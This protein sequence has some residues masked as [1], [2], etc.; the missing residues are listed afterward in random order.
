[1][2]FQVGHHKR[3]KEG[4]KKKKHTYVTPFLDSI[5]LAATDSINIAI[6]I[7]EGKACG[8]I[9]KSGRIPVAP[10]NGISTSGHSW[11]QTP[12]CPCLLLN[13]SP[14]TG[15]RGC[16]KRIFTLIGKKK[17][18]QED[19]IRLFLFPRKQYQLKTKKANDKF[20]TNRGAKEITK[21]Q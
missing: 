1:M 8:L 12:F 20:N 13:L 3:K 2:Y 4:K 5:T 14:I 10:E 21:I 9:I 18:K 15:F 11:E 16:R 19:L 6:V 17:G 7:L